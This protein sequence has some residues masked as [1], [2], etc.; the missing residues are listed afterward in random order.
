MNITAAIK[1]IRRA[2]ERCAEN[3]SML[4]YGGCGVFALALATEL[5]KRQMPF[6]LRIFG[7]RARV[8]VEEG[9][10]YAK[11]NGFLTDPIRVDGF[12]GDPDFRAHIVVEVEGQGYDCEGEVSLKHWRRWKAYPDALPVWALRAWVRT[13]SMWNDMYDREQNPMVRRL[14]KEAFQEVDAQA[15][16]QEWNE[17]LTREMFA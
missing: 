7:G 4:N 17:T 1:A 2:G 13:P 10:N 6:A 9:V 16:A 14:V 12:F 11:Q 5:Q 3:I 8:N 15:D